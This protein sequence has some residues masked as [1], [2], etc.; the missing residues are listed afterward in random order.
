MNV[1]PPLAP[2]LLHA[3]L[4]RMPL[5]R[6]I[7][8]G[9]KQVFETLFTQSSQSFRQVV[10]I[11]Y[12]KKGVWTLGLVATERHDALKLFS[13]ENVLTVFIPTTPNPTSGYLVIVSPEDVREIDFTVEEAFKFIV[14]GGTTRL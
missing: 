4:D 2:A 10:L 12:P 7:Y 8:K 1:A 6:S 14:S 5:V 9:L 13:T 3:L 11:E